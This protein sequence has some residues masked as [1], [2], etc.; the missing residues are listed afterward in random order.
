MAEK[1]IP[2][3]RST[4]ALILSVLVFPPLGLVLLWMRPK[5]GVLRRVFGSLV[6]LVIGV[7]HLF[8][9]YGLHV[10]MDGTGMKPI[11]SFQKPSVQ[12]QRLE[13]HRAA[14]EA[15]P[16]APAAVVEAAAPAPSTPT[17]SAYWA[18]FRG[19]GRLGHYD[20]KPILTSW[21]SSGLERLWKQPIGGGYASFS[22]AGETAYTIEQRRGSEVVAAYNI[23]TG[24]ELWTN[25]WS[26]LF[27]EGMGGDG[28][29]ATPVYDN[30][31]VYALGAE[32]EFRC[33]DAATGRTI[34]N[35]NILADNGAQNITWAMSNA[36]LIVE[37][38]VIVTPGGD[39]GRSIVAYDKISGKRLW[40]SLDDKASYTSP[41]LVTL[42]GKRQILAVTATRAVGLTVEE[43]SLLWE[44]PWSTQYDINCAQPIVTARNRFFISAGYGHGAALVELTPEGDKFLTKT[45]WANLRM[46]N[47]FNSSVMHEGHI[48]GL[49]EGILAC[50]KAD[51]GE[52]TWKGGRYGYGQLLLASGHLVVLSEDGDLALVRATP[53]KH[54]ELTRFN[55]IDGKTWNHPAI[56][57]GLLLV[58]N[59]TEMACFRLAK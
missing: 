5:T 47:K 1:R 4:V 36:P 34:W 33:I 19:P 21:P 44:Y 25:S 7:V 46:K 32:G 56:S 53:A 37:G 26:A 31:R 42:G 17:I 10:E 38:K 41:M 6:I 28:P 23:R 3:Y 49:D 16:P 20:E 22:V 59:T 45:L 55:A 35:I 58:R 54:E 43:G 27:Q 50:I 30:G 2:W 9:F 52:Q 48:Y 8:A 51:T 39:K 57:G 13:E 29:R 12:Q 18:D 24:R 15:T 40:S 14:Q 11:F